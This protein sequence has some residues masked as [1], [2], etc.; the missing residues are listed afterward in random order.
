[1]H[2]IKLLD[3]MMSLIYE[4]VHTYI[5]YH[6]LNTNKESMLHMNSSCRGGFCIF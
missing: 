5:D 3:G 4:T 1:M 6:K 2:L